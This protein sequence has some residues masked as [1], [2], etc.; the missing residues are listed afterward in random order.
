MSSATLTASAANNAARRGNALG[1][2][3]LII[4]AWLVFAFFLLLP[5]FA[6]SSSCVPCSCIS[7]ISSRATKGTV[8]KMVAR[9]MPGRAKM[10][11]ISCSRNQGPK[12]PWA[13]NSST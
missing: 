1:R 3:L 8:T 6:A 7:G 11:W 12:K 13:P 9:T 2:R 5:L 10:I 4:S